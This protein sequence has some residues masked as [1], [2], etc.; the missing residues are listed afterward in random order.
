MKKEAVVKLIDK[1]LSPMKFTKKGAVW[2]RQSEEWIDAVDVQ[3]GRFDNS[4]TLNFGVAHREVF[5]T[6]RSQECVGFIDPSSCTVGARIGTL[7][8][9]RKDLWWDLQ[10]NQCAEELIEHLIR[11]GFPFLESMHSLITMRD[12]LD[13]GAIKT[14]LQPGSEINCA[15]IESMLG[16]SLSACRRLA[17]FQKKTISGLWRQRAGEIG[18][19]IGC[20]R[21]GS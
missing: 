12:S 10:S 20:P 16:S 2:N 6:F 1:I 18:D 5:S 3:K 8:P 14:D 9:G 21:V 11:F 17:E 4:V 13:G 7:T 19:K 15:I